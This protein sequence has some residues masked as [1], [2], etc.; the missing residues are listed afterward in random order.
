VFDLRTFAGFGDT[1]GTWQYGVPFSCYTDNTTT[2]PTYHV[3][4]EVAPNSA[5]FAV[6]GTVPYT[7]AASIAACNAYFEQPYPPFINTY[8]IAV[9]WPDG[10]LAGRSWD[11]SA[12]PASASAA[13]SKGVMPGFQ[14]TTPPASPPAPLLL[15]YTAFN[16]GGPNIFTEET[17]AQQNAAN[18]L[19]KSTPVPRRVI[20]VRLAPTS[21][22][23]QIRTYPMRKTFSILTGYTNTATAD[24]RVLQSQGDIFML[25]ATPYQGS[26][27]TAEIYPMVYTNTL[28]DTQA[29]TSASALHLQPSPT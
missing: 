22:P 27:T 7:G 20:R 29:W 25:A 23:A 12:A 15:T 11:I 2:P 9:T 3:I 18:L 8:Q 26:G 17:S 6:P 5:A 28:V 16:P 21:P 24:P 13:L 10:T 14:I 19:D 1:S 4:V